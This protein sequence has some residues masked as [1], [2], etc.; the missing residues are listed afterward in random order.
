MKQF[1]KT[2]S[3]NLERLREIMSKRKPNFWNVTGKRVIFKVPA[4]D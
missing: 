4:M 3:L 1:E 2:I